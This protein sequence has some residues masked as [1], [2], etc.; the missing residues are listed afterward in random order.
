MRVIQKIICSSLLFLL[1]HFTAAAQV[2]NLDVRGDL[3][4]SDELEKLT[5]YWIVGETFNKD[6][7]ALFE[8]MV[9]TFEKSIWEIRQVNNRLIFFIFDRDLVFQDSRVENGKV[10]AKLTKHTIS[11]PELG[12]PSTISLQLKFGNNSFIGRLTYPSFSLTIRGRLDGHL[13]SSRRRAASVE[14]EMLENIEAKK[15]LSNRIELLMEENDKLKA[16]RNENKKLKIDNDA[17][18]INTR[19]W[20]NRNNEVRERNIRLKKIIRGLYIQNNA[21]RQKKEKSGKI[22]PDKSLGSKNVEATG[23]VSLA[24]SNLSILVLGQSHIRAEPNISSVVVLKAREGD[25]FKV[26][27]HTIDHSWYKLEKKGVVIG[28][29]LSEMVEVK[30]E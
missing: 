5:G 11:D 7:N 8:W 13:I 24:T 20:A 28:Y 4:L 12:T 6:S 22:V 15:T 29:I 2:E 16:L 18:S 21:L 19:R 1:I 26:I 17:L 23:I 25:I 30:L 9:P 3:A 14:K 10:Q 27:G